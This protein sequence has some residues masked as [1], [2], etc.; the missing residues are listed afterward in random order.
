MD[1][2]QQEL[3]ARGTLALT[4]AQSSESRQILVTLERSLDE[5]VG[6]PGTLNILG[7]RIQG[8]Q[9][10][11]YSPVLAVAV[12]RAAR[13]W[14]LQELP[15]LSPR[16]PRAAKVLGVLEEA[17]PRASSKGIESGQSLSIFLEL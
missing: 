2:P 8:R 15:E 5:K 10:S 13:L 1:I 6:T 12:V 16:V 7:K 17:T 4:S 3:L 11:A 9:G 14:R